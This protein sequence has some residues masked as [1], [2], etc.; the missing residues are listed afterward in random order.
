MEIMRM[1]SREGSRSSSRAQHS[2]RFVRAAVVAALLASPGFA[3]AKDFVPNLGGGLNELARA[4]GGA[5]PSGVSQ[6]KIQH[7]VK[8][9]GTGRALVK[10]LL[11]GKVSGAS[12]A[13]ALRN[14]TDVEILA[15]DM[16]FRGT[17]V[18]EAYVPASAL[19]SIA[20]SPGV[21]TVVP[22]GQAMT[23]VGAATTQAIVQHRINRLPAGV[24]GSGITVGVLSDSY[25]TRVSPRTDAAADVAS[26]DLPGVGNPLG[27][28]EP[29][30]VLEELHT[31]GL[32]E[33]R[34]MLQVVHDLA[35]KARLG[36]A[37]AFKGEVSFVNNIRALAGFPDAPNFVPGFKADVIVDDI[38]YFTEPFFQDGIIAQAADEVAAAGV[39]Y[40]ASA[41]NRPGPQSYDARPSIV[42]ARPADSTLNFT[43]VDPALYAGGF[44]DFDD[45]LNGVDIAQTIQAT[46]NSKIIF[47][48]NEPYDSRPPTPIGAPIASGTGTVP[49]SGESR[50]TFVGTV[51]QALEIFID[52]DRSTTGIPHPDLTFALVGPDG[53]EVRFVD[54]GTNPEFIQF[55]P[56]IAGTHTVIVRSFAAEQFGDFLYRVQPV[57]PGAPRVLTDYNILLFL[58]DGTFAGALAEPNL[59]TNRPLELGQFRE[60]GTFQLV[61]ARGNRPTASPNVA[62]RIRY[63][64]V[65]VVT[66][67]EYFKYLSPVTFGHN[68]A[69]GSMGVAA[70]GFYAPFAPQTFQSPGPSTI[71]FDA[72]GVRLSSVETREKPDLAAMDGGNNTFFGSDTPAD[73]DTL[74]NFFGTSA[75][76]P[77]AAGIA[78]LVLDAAGGPGSVRPNR[79]RTILQQS[80]FPHDL[81]P[82]FA[83]GLAVSPGSSLSFTAQSDQS[84]S[85]Q[86]DANAF[87]LTQFGSRNVLSLGINGGN[88]NPTQSPR[89]I[90]FDERPTTGQPFV[91]GRT[92]GISPAEVTA[93]LSLPAAP[94]GVAGQWNQLNLRFAPGSFGVNNLISFGIDRD[95]ADGAGGLAAAGGNSADLLGEGVLI[96]SG[97]L[98]PG[99]A[100]F[101]GTLDNNSTFSGAFFNSIGTGYS[102][103]DG[104]G[105]IN[106]EAAV[107]AV[108]RGTQD[109]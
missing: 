100:T 53:R 93:T 71:Y 21:D 70:Y 83:R 76:A 73:D 105:F 89:G 39:V 55:S 98:A 47:Q 4:A 96:P 90:V 61:I 106:A 101:F 10:I 85:G 91:I 8:L 74:P 42:A 97:V 17:G 94:P 48:W 102:R 22:S 66:V 35:P 64:G 68:S 92:R 34:A 36:F 30:V 43:G 84:A 19:V 49:P 63:V 6:S 62:D 99:G 86:F 77:H 33:G 44:H 108:L 104:Y 65:D 40:F 13:Q 87:T 41:G 72:N 109:K 56:R 51:G 54:E 26:A 37:T 82:F 9:D 46:A 28:I 29:V 1:E 88:G 12:V 25:D 75:A 7:L 16:K 79:M 50:F 31:P 52:S 69:R 5:Q 15:T 78:A 38:F 58:P 107:N 23:N 3:V 103:A 67:Q 81:D 18:I 11:D 27:N 24:D 59:T 95:E 60:G 45:S 32:D 80:A 57:D 2:S 20:K 14:R